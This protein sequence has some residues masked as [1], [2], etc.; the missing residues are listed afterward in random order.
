MDRLPVFRVSWAPRPM[1][2]AAF[3]VLSFFMDIRFLVGA[4]LGWKVLAQV[5]KGKLGRP[6]VAVKGAPCM[7]WWPGEA[8]Q[9]LEQGAGTYVC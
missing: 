7:L 1:D 9:S 4:V 2:S 8:W 5:S 6:P 3:G